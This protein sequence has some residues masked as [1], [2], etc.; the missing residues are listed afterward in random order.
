MKILIL[1]ANAGHGHRKVAEVTRDAFLARGLAKDQVD[2]Q[3]ALDF[4]PAFFRTLYPAIYFYSVKHTP[5]VWG[6]FYET[7]D[8][9]QVY[10]WLKPFRS[11]AN[12][13]VGGKLLKK[14]LSEKPDVIICSHFFSARS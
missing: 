7:F 8:F 5:D 11:W 13:M 2:V 14:V 4:T 9:T 12:R 1:H 10:R 6:W 3:D